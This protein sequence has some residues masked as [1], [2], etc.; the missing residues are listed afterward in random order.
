MASHPTAVANLAFLEEAE[1]YN[2]GDSGPPFNDVSTLAFAVPLNGTI[3]IEGLMDAFNLY[4]T[5]EFNMAAGATRL[6]IKARWA[7][8]YDDMDLYFGTSTGFSF[9]SIETDGDTEPPG[10]TTFSFMSLGPSTDYELGVQ[11]WLANNTS[12][13]TGQKYVLLLTGS[14]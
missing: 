14:P 12:G 13:S 3:A 4:D 10:G 6:S 9:D 11:F 8:G 1:P 5:Y 2:N 7:T